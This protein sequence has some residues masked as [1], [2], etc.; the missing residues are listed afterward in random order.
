MTYFVFG[1][2]R[3]ARGKLYPLAAFTNKR[4]AQAY[5]K[6]RNVYKGLRCSV[7]AYTEA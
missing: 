2:Y 3:K 5:A 4:R 7:K 6:A 1:E